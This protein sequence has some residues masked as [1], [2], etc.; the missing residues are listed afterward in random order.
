M[1]LKQMSEWSTFAHHRGKHNTN[2]ALLT[3]FAG[4]VKQTIHF[5]VAVISFMMLI[6]IS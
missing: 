5:D 2:G 3:P 4:M 6:K 1:F